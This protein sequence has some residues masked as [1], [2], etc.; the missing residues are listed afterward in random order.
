MRSIGAPARRIK[1]SVSSLRHYEQAGLLLSFRSSCRAPPVLA[2]TAIK[3]DRLKAA[4]T[5]NW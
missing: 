4:L 1:A 5:L 3:A 2:A